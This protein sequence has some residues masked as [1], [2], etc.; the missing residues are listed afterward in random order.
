VRSV[1]PGELAGRAGDGDPTNLHRVIPAEGGET[2]LDPGSLSVY[3]VTSSGLVP[4]R[5]HLEVA[6]A[7]IAGGAT[8]VQLRAP[9]VTDEELV[10]LARELEARCASAGVLFVVNDRVNVAGAVGAG[11]HVGQDDDPAAARSVLGAGAVLGV[12]VASPE[13]AA[14]AEHAGADYLGVTVWATPT[15]PEAHPVGVDGIRAIARATRLPVVGIGGIDATNAGAVIA[16]GASGVAVVSAV[17]AAAD[18][19]AAT[20]RLVDAVK[21][22]R[23]TR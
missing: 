7:A 2:A 17:G 6:T 23:V 10:P 14:V 21:A 19:E 5:G 20:R 18:P 9:E 16:A 15:K 13:Q 11:A 22:A 8:A 3:V 4:G 1:G 12:S